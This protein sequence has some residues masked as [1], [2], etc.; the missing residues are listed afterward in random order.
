MKVFNIAS[1]TSLG[2]GGCHASSMILLAMELAGETSFPL[3]YCWNLAGKNLI[4]ILLM[5]E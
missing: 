1:R 2:N 4:S 5:N 3:S